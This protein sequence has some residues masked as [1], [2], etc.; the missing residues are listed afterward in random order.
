MALRILVRQKENKDNSNNNNSDSS[1]Y[2]S[3]HSRTVHADVHR[4]QELAEELQPAIE[5]VLKYFQIDQLEAPFI[6]AYRKDYL[7]PVLQRSDLWFIQAQDV[8]YE[9]VRAQRRRLLGEIQ[10]I[11]DAANISGTDAQRLEEHE[12]ELKL[13][14]T[15]LEDLFDA[16]RMKVA[17]KDDSVLAAKQSLVEAQEV[18]AVDDDGDDD[19]AEMLIKSK[20]ESL[21]EAEREAEAARISS[22]EANAAIG[23]L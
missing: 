18:N 12:Q 10:A 16:E 4:V 13:E 19:F 3:Y 23:K 5:A 14:I 8:K 21:A 15:R 20:Q 2:S 1:S 22:D 17:E 11:C 9:H 7:H 6:W